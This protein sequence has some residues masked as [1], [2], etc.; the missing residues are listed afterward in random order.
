MVMR[1]KIWFINTLG[2]SPPVFGTASRMKLKL[3]VKRFEHTHHF[4]VF[5]K[6]RST[7]LCWSPSHLCHQPLT[8]HP[9]DVTTN[10]HWCPT[11]LPPR[12]G[13]RRLRS[14]RTLCQNIVLLHLG[15]RIRCGLLRPNV[16]TVRFTFVPEKSSVVQFLLPGWPLTVVPVCFYSIPITTVT[17]LWRKMLCRWKVTTFLLS[18]GVQQTCD[19]MLK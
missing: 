19:Q 5:Q 1:K 9:I 2:M 17:F 4:T 7:K 6:G 11:P 3:A 8:C 15:S 16:G 10:P 13:A 12:R 18:A 14:N